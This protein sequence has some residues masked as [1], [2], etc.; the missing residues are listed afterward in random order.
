MGQVRISA[1]WSR[2]HTDVVGRSSS[3]AGIRKAMRMLGPVEDYFLSTVLEHGSVGP[4]LRAGAWAV[5]SLLERRPLSLQATLF[6]EPSRHRSLADA[7]VRA[8][9]DVVYLDGA[10]TF[11]FFLALHQQGKVRRLVVDFDDLMSR[12]M[13]EY[14][15]SGLVPLGYVA[16]M[17]PHWARTLVDQRVF[18]RAMLAYER[19]M[20]ERVERLMC[21]RADAVVLVSPVDASILR[22][23]LPP[24]MGHKV[25]VIPPC[26]D[27]V[28]PVEATRV[29]ITFVFMG[30]DEQAHNR[31]TIDY[32]LSIWKSCRPAAPLV[33]AGPMTRTWPPVENV[34]F[35]G[36]IENASDLY[37]PGAVMLA[38]SFIRGGV[39]TKVL[40]AFAHGCAAVG[41]EATFEG[42]PLNGYP[43]CLT[44]DEQLRA[45]L[46]DLPRQVDALHDAAAFG[47]ERL[48]EYFSRER[49]E[50]AWQRV[51]SGHP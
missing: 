10:R 14:R 30:S 6:A 38:P 9:P 8:E 21:E 45:F 15:Q 36:W 11:P 7:V 51:L 40:Q 39:K 20:L 25:E 18:G 46:A 33:I 32:L 5:G 44:S 16:N 23:R 24:A 22:D 47:Q 2:R 50:R 48:R 26:V 28:R 3:V 42:L 37:T 31:L 13:S 17:L 43:F 29:P 27:V 12:R 19:V 35:T 49:F 41:T 34:R 4:A 1:V